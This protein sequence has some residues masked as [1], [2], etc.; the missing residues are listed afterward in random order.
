MIMRG[1]FLLDHVL[2]DL[3][4]SIRSIRKDVRFT[5]VAVFA[6]AVGI[7]AGTRVFRVFYN[8]LFNAVAARD[9]QRLVVPVMQNAET[10]EFTNGLWISWAG[11]KYVCEQNQVFE[12]VVGSHSGIARVQYGT[13]SYQ[14]ENG[15]VSPD[16]PRR[17]H[18]RSRKQ[19]P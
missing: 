18:L 14:F 11:V 2:G 17:W 10:P 3:R 1:L 19:W 12:N 5:F 13:Q 6:L 4:Y 7:G 15:H 16:A 9:A 8:F